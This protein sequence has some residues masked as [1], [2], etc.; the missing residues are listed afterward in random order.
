MEQPSLKL[1]ELESSIGDTATGTFLTP[2]NDL[3]YSS[4]IYCPLQAQEKEI[5]LLRLL[6]G[7][8]E[9][10]LS[11][12]IIDQVSLSDLGIEYQALSYCAGDVNDNE[13]IKVQGLDFNIFASVGAALR[14]L[15]D[16]VSSSLLWIDQICIDQSNVTER[17]QQV[18]LMRS[19]YA[20]ATKTVVWLGEDLESHS[21]EI[22]VSFLQGIYQTLAFLK[23]LESEDHAAFEAFPN[24]SRESER[25]DCESKLMQSVPKQTLREN[26]Y[27]K[28]ARWLLAGM[29]QGKYSRE[30][31]AVAT[32][33]QMG[34]FFYVFKHACR[35]Q[36][37]SIYIV[38][39]LCSVSGM[40]L[41]AAG[42]ALSHVHTRLSLSM[43]PPSSHAS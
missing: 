38:E 27:L 40:G 30:L 41:M 36:L 34:K 13:L 35:E 37:S 14:R 23:T 8:S 4:K 25:H 6:P 31:A 21:E 33:A 18:L 15:R 9:D 7:Q 39:N 22:A 20:S 24:F 16:P 1:K 2:E 3:F 43:S 17:E 29:G 10:P 19:I 12:E 28:T 42:I 5:R 26:G 11:L 32:M